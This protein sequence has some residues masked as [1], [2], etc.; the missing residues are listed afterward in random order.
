M[1]TFSART[2]EMEEAAL[3]GGAGSPG[4]V[5]TDMSD[6]VGDGWSIG[7]RLNGPIAFRGMFQRRNLLRVSERTKELHFPSELRAYTVFPRGCGEEKKPSPD[8][9]P[10]LIPG[11]RTTSFLVAILACRRSLF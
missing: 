2:F 10:R 5:A 1:A 4:G 8:T 11:L 3:D 7:R 9:V 6:I